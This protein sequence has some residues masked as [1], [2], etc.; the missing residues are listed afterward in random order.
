MKRISMRLCRALSTLGSVTN[1][2]RGGEELQLQDLPK[3]RDSSQESTIRGFAS[4]S[5]HFQTR[6]P[7]VSVG[8]V[9]L[10]FGIV[11]PNGEFIS[12]EHVGICPALWANAGITKKVARAQRLIGKSES[13]GLDSCC[14]KPLCLCS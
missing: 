14:A 12:L 1:A 6:F 10:F 4:E 13:R 3:L 8:R 7:W 5:A 2:K 9:S 11:P